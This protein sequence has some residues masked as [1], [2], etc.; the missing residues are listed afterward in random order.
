[1]GL[2]ALVSSRDARVPGSGPGE[3][4]GPKPLGMVAVSCRCQSTSAGVIRVAILDGEPIGINSAQGY[5]TPEDNVVP[6]TRH[7]I[8]GGGDDGLDTMQPMGLSGSDT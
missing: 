5:R 1:M 6:D 3:S 8:P 2:E 4:G 7:Q